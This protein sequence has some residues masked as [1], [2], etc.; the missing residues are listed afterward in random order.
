VGKTWGIGE[1]RRVQAS[2][3]GP[4]NNKLEN[5]LPLLISKKAAYISWSGHY[6]RGLWIPKG[7]KISPSG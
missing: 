3:A 5:E 6:H 2:E 7:K 1:F 4:K